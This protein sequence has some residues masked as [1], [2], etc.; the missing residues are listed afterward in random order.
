MRQKSSSI[1]APRLGQSGLTVPHGVF[2]QRSPSV[3][4]KFVELGTGLSSDTHESV[5]SPWNIRR[6]LSYGAPVPQVGIMLV[7]WTDCARLRLRSHAVHC[8]MTASEKE[9]FPAISPM[10]ITAQQKPSSMPC[11][12]YA[13]NRN[14]ACADNMGSLFGRTGRRNGS[15]V[16][17]PCVS[18]SDYPHHSATF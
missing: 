17:Q 9:D 4:E 14:D 6:S 18:S 7:A 11:A 16:M 8:S 2:C 12:L 3:G 1:F 10:D 15:W 13:D 5:L